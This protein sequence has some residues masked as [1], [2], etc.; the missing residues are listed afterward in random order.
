MPARRTLRDQLADLLGRFLVVG[1]RARLL[2]QDLAAV[3]WHID[4]QPA[5]EAQILVAV[6]L[7]PQLADIEVERLL[8]I[9]NVDRR[10]RE[11]VEHRYDL[12]VGD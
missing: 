1:G 6:H 12:P 10:D 5:H 11:S 2:Q 7:E 8:L 4:G 9:E 3:T